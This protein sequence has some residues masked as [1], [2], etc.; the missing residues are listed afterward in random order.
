M[1]GNQWRVGGGG[2]DSDSN[3]Y[4]KTRLK[5][6]SRGELGKVKDSGEG[7]TR[8]FLHHDASTAAATRV[9]ILLFVLVLHAPGDAT[10]LGEVG[11][12]C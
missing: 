9:A 3:F 2:R 1:G 7:W 4:N 6:S 10:P 11:A 12:S 5:G 8:R